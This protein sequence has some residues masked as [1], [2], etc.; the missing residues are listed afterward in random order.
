MRLQGTRDREIS[1]E[2]SQ[3]ELRRHRLTFNEI[4]NKVQRASL[5]LTFGE[6]R[7]DAGGFILHTVAKRRFGT[8]SATFR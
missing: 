3:E 6:L 5:N 2:L 4:T 8:S 7:T 1:I